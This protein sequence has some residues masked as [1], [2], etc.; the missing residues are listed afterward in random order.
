[1]GIPSLDSELGKYWPLLTPVQKES[2]LSVIKSF[3]APAERI[4]AEQ[5]NKEIDEAVARV[6]AGEFYTQ[7][8]VDKMAK[9]W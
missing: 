7:D 9:E 1:M 2:L 8:D 4:S 3:V 6:E 5:Y